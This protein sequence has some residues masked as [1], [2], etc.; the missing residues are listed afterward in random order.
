MKRRHCE[1]LPLFLHINSPLTIYVIDN[2]LISF[3]EWFGYDRFPYRA[4]ELLHHLFSSQLRER[5]F[6]NSLAKIFRNLK[7]L[8]EIPGYHCLIGTEYPYPDGKYMCLKCDMQII[9]TEQLP[10]KFHNFSLEEKPLNLEV[11]VSAKEAFYILSNQCVDYYLH[12]LLKLINNEKSNFVF[13]KEQFTKTPKTDIDV[14]VVDYLE[15]IKSK[16]I[17]QTITPI[18]ILR[19]GGIAV[20]ELLSGMKEIQNFF[21]EVMD[22]LEYNENLSIDLKIMYYTLIKCLNKPKEPL[23]SIRRFYKRNKILLEELR[24][25]L[26]DCLNK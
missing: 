14:F 15:H 7:T 2:K 24:K 1:N 16:L 19:M 18:Q 25:E 4:F 11:E 9:P 20:I 26:E 6:P 23:M 13:S 3:K 12:S 17:E 22:E 8:E 10:I 21:V 5:I